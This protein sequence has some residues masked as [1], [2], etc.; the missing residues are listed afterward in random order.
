MRTV[1]E[2][3]LGSLLFGGLMFIGL[4]AGFNLI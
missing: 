1:L 2:T 4:L 3:I